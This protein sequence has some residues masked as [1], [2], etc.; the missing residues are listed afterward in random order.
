MS[1]Q[2]YDYS[3]L[4]GYFNI[5]M[6]NKTSSQKLFLISKLSINSLMQMRQPVEAE[7][8]EQKRKW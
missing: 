6:I 7:K 4:S 3:F 5:N 2:M 8:A 1:F